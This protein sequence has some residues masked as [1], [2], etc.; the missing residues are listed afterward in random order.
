MAG[1]LKNA[2]IYWRLLKLSLFGGK[3]SNVVRVQHFHP[4]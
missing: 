1:R 2:L 4:A 3:A